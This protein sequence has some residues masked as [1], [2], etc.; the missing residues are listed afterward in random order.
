MEK[1]ADD[2]LVDVQWLVVKDGP[3]VFQVAAKV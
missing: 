1:G 2:L 3:E